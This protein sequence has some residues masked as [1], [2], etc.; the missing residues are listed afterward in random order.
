MVFLIFVVIFS[1]IE[2]KSEYVIGLKLK[3][4]SDWFIKI[5]VSG[6]LDIIFLVFIREYVLYVEELWKDVVI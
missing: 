1:E 2:D 3:V 4:F 5:M 6:N